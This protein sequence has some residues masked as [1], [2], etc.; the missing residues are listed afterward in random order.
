MNGE[1]VGDDVVGGDG[2][3]L[4]D[5][6]VSVDSMTMDG[7]TNGRNGRSRRT[8]GKQELDS[9]PDRCSADLFILLTIVFQAQT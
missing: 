6:V 3:R 1:A 8:R 9:Q 4:G 7:S 5:L 2:F